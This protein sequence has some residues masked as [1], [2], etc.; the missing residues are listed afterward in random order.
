MLSK[1]TLQ[2][3]ERTFSSEIDEL[4][5]AYTADLN[6]LHLK[7]AHARKLVQTD[8]IKKSGQN[9]PKTSILRPL[10]KMATWSAGDELS[11]AYDF[12][13]IDPER[14]RAIFAK[15]QRLSGVPSSSSPLTGTTNNNVPSWPPIPEESFAQVAP[16]ISRSSSFQ[17][18]TDDQEY[19]AYDTAS[20]ATSVTGF[21]IQTISDC[22]PD[23]A[24]SYPS[25]DYNQSSMLSRS[26]SI[27]TNSDW[28]GIS[29]QQEASAGDYGGSQVSST[30]AVS[31]GTP[32]P[33]FRA[34]D[35][36]TGSTLSRSGSISSAG[37]T[38]TPGVCD[39]GEEY[40]PSQRSVFSQDRSTPAPAVYD[41]GEEYSSQRSVCSDARFLPPEW[42]QRDEYSSQRSVYS[43]DS[44]STRTP[45]VCDEGEEYSSS[46][47][48]VYS[49]D[50]SPT[51][52]PGACDQLEEPSSQVCFDLEARRFSVPAAMAYNDQD[53]ETVRSF[54]SDGDEASRVPWMT[55]PF[56]SGRI[57][58]GT[59]S[60]VPTQDPHNFSRARTPFIVEE[61]PDITFIPE[62]TPD[63]VDYA[64]VNEKWLDEMA[65]RKKEYE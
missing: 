21:L 31:L 20:Q 11:S 8:G 61:I 58:N 15:D 4:E 10:V 34:D 23:R 6:A 52:T 53:A 47:R 30:S 46:Q 16:S 39:Q 13:V 5:R 1:T 33:S 54:S 60:E 64:H 43:H 24:Y 48:S 22:P 19:T 59:E 26:S 44:S 32:E 49:Q 9:R 56:T 36:P 18:V 57:I 62:G 12:P 2:S 25:N 37:G 45:V 65:T 14:S 3:Q 17:T 41:Q 29:S 50:R 7:Y 42:A 28:Q 40:F 27:D 63:I 55:S 51:P 38:P 35:P